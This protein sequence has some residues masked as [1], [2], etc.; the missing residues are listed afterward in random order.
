MDSVLRRRLI[1]CNG[2]AFC[3]AGV[4]VWKRPYRETA[5]ELE[6]PA[7][8]SDGLGLLLRRDQ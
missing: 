4:A 5:I 6:W 7:S 8:D 1:F 3:G 2:A